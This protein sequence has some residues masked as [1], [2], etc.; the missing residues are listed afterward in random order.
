MELGRRG[1]NRPGAFIFL[2]GPESLSQGPNGDEQQ[3]SQN[4]NS[5][6]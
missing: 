2:L 1:K 6:R 5:A 3:R 4:E